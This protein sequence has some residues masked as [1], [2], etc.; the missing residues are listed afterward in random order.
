MNSS[1][2]PG[3][4]EID[5]ES[6]EALVEVLVARQLRSLPKDEMQKAQLDRTYIES[7]LTETYEEICDKRRSAFVKTLPQN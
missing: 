1:V 2:D 6:E 7:V 5:E 4:E 3:E